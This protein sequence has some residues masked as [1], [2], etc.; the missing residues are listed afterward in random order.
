M[1]KVDGYICDFCKAAKSVKRVYATKGSCAR[2]ESSCYRNPKTKSCATCALWILDDD[3]D[4]RFCLD[5]HDCIDTGMCNGTRFDPA[6]QHYCEFW[7]AKE[8]A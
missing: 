5:E 4:W 3:R 7:K 1:I 6:P 2:H 8:A